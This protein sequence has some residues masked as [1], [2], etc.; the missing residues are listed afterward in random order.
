MPKKAKRTSARRSSAPLPCPDDPKE[1]C[2][3][4]NA[5]A[6]AMYAWALEV[7]AA[8]NDPDGP[9]APPKPPFKFP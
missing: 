2:K 1:V 5:W 9:T 3:K 7:N 4:L 6:A 8:I